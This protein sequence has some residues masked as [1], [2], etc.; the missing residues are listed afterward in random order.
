MGSNKTNRRRGQ[1]RQRRVPRA[2]PVSTPVSKVQREELRIK[3]TSVLLYAAI[4]LMRII[5]ERLPI[6]WPWLYEPDLA[7]VLSRSA[8]LLG[9]IY[10]LCMV[11]K[12]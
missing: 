4:E 3:W 8:T 2:T 11:H 9:H 12:R 6:R 7:Y 1:R 5:V 10:S